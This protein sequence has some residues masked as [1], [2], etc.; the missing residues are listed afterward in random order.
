[1]LTQCRGEIEPGRV[2][3]LGDGI[4]AFVQDFV[5]DLEALIGQPDLVRIRVDEEP[6]D[7]AGPVN[8]NPTATLHPDIPGG[9]LDPGQERFDPRPEAGHDG[10]MLLAT[11]P[12]TGPVRCRCGSEPDQGPAG[13]VVVV[14]V[15][16]VEV[17]AGVV[18]LVDVV[19][20][21]VGGIVGGTVGGAVEG[22]TSEKGAGTF[23]PFST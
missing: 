18:V 17:L 10:P 13:A 8:R 2:G 7:R 21:S 22:G 6:R 9:L 16:V 23:G 20:G 11:L 12:P 14:V 3:P 19:G 4:V 5:Q 1:M 15:D